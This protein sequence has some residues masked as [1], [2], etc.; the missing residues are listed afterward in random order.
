MQG[1]WGD[2]IEKVPPRKRTIG[3]WSE[4]REVRVVNSKS[5]AI[6]GVAIARSGDVGV[7]CEGSRVDVSVLRVTRL[8][9]VRRSR[10]RFPRTS[11]W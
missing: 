8:E 2:S 7:P 9:G 10:M 5:G 3:R 1:A 11:A 4:L 6:S